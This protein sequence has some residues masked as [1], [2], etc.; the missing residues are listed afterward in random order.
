MASTDS[1]LI[2]RDLPDNLK[3]VY[4]TLLEIKREMEANNIEPPVVI[5]I[6]DIAKDYDDLLARLELKE[7][8]RLG[9][10]KLRGFVSNLKPAKTRAGFGRGALDLLGLPLVPNAKGTRGF[11]KE[12]EDKHKLHDYEFDCSFIKEGEVKE[13]GRDLLY[14]LLKDALDAREEV[15]LLCLSSLRDIAKFAR[16]YP[17][18]LRRALKKGKVVL[19]GGYSVVDG[20]LKASVVNKN[21][22]I[23]GAANNNFDPTAAIEFHKFLQE[24]KIQSIVFDRDAALNLKRP[25]PR[26]MFTDMARTGEIGQYLDRVAERQESKFFLDATGHPENRFGYKAPTATDPGSE[27]HDWNRYKGRVK[28][29]P[30]DKPRPATFEELRPYTDVIAYDALAT[31]GVLRKRDID[32]LKIIEPRSSEW[33]DTIHQVVGNGSEPNS[34]DGT[35][36]GMCTALEALLRGSLLAVSQGLCSNPI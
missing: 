20:N 13:K 19:Q 18:L 35:G 8:H 32:K 1:P 7:F 31:L 30:K 27:G 28:R 14:R 15:I 9:L 11:P 22:K 3:P 16:K 25:L 5:A 24:K 23:Q 10:I 36:N 17:N 2:P 33:P 6:D 29:W 26:T 12:D 34:L 21:L 4:R